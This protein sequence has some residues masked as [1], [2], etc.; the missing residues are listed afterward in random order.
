MTNN[1]YESIRGINWD[2]P[3]KMRHKITSCYIKE[4][5]EYLLDMFSL[6]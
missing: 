4:E 6:L 2:F 1:N 5:R 3:V